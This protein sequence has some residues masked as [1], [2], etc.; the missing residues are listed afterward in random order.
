MFPVEMTQRPLPDPW[1]GCL[2]RRNV[3]QNSVIKM[4]S[5][6]CEK[7][8]NSVLVPSVSKSWQLL[9]VKTSFHSAEPNPA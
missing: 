1:V 4:G 3:P 5:V 2:G 7:T 6:R 9:E 8:Q